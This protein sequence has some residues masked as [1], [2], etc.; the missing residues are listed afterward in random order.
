M[1]KK[2]KGEKKETRNTHRRTVP[3]RSTSDHVVGL[4]EKRE[5]E[6]EREGERGEEE[7]EGDER[8]GE[9]L[10]EEKESL[11]EKVRFSDRSAWRIELGVRT[12]RRQK[13]PLSC[14]S[15]WILVPPGRTLLLCTAC[16]D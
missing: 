3:E 12:W 8:G 4:P 13:L 7:E 2:E 1:K 6:G 11:K 10:G 15:V 16:L 14:E 5:R 9:G